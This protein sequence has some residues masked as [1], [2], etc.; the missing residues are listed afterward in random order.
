MVLQG[1]NWDRSVESLAPDTGAGILSAY[2][3]S[4]DGQIPATISMYTDNLELFYLWGTWLA[5]VAECVTLD[6]RIVS[7]SP[8]L[9]V[10][11]TQK[12]T[13]NKNILFVNN[14][15]FTENF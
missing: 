3:M 7:S 2:C 1:R 13:N 9:R 10:E 11:F 4:E 14:L 8:K 6:P 15:K 12:Q 5:Q